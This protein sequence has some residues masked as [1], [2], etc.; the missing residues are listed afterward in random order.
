MSPVR[1]QL[2]N[3]GGLR[4]SA[5]AIFATFVALT[6]HIVGGGAMPAIMGVVVPL[7]LSFLVCVLLAGR[8]LSLPRLSLS[9]LAS[10]TL[11][12]LLFSVFT[13][14]GAGHGPANAVE[15]HAAHHAGQTGMSASM[16]GMSET[17]PSSM[18]GAGADVGMHSH[19]S[20]MMLISHLV[21]AAITIAMIYWSE[22]LP[23][24]IAGFVRLVL[25]ALLPTMVRLTSVPSGPKPHLVVAE[26]L[27]RHLGVLRSPV[28]IRGPP[29][30][31]V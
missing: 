26:I 9:V 16:P 27:P 17:M 13:P 31:A 23:A 7:A 28:L 11:F 5:A 20:P 1:S 15:R 30:E 25:H 2:R 3:R 10:Q 8:R 6:S 21:A 12:H 14:A 29:A 18:P 24:K 22:T 19:A 4:G